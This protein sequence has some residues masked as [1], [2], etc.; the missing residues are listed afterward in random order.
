[1]VNYTF[2]LITNMWICLNVV[3]YVR[4]N[5][6]IPKCSNVTNDT[7][8]PFEYICKCSNEFGHFHSNLILEATK[9]VAPSFETVTLY[10]EIPQN[11]PQKVS[12]IFFLILSITGTFKRLKYQF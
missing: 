4:I 5:R 9:T 6:K 8:D 3:F 10:S 1:M 11:H 2:E 12:V 7:L